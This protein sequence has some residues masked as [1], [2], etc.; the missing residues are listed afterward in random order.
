[1]ACWALHARLKTARCRLRCYWGGRPLGLTARPVDSDLKMGKKLVAT[2]SWL[3]TECTVSSSM[4]SL[5]TL[6][7][8]FRLDAQRTASWCRV[9]QSSQTR[10][11]ERYTRTKK[12]D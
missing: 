3:Q 5:I 4:L 2:W 6:H 1:M 12:R 8:L 11:F 10:S 7:L 9:V